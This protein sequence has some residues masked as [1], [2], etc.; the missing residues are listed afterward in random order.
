MEREK[1]SKTKRLKSIG[2]F[3]WDLTLAMMASHCEQM[4][5]ESENDAV[6][7]ILSSFQ[8]PELKTYFEQFTTFSK[9]SELHGRQC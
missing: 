4:P 5:V 1:M 9:L 8:E 6:R 3:W 2:N 7:L